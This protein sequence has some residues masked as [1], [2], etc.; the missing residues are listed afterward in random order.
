MNPCSW[1]EGWRFTFLVVGLSEVL[2]PLR[3]C[4]GHGASG[5]SP[6]QGPMPGADSGLATHT[7]VL[8]RIV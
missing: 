8:L 3:L 1:R 6:T 2:H 4:L 5:V 7:A